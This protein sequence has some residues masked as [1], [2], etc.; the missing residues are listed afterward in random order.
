LATDNAKDPILSKINASPEMIG[1][2]TAGIAMG[3]NFDRLVDT[4]MSET[5]NY[6]ASWISGN[7]F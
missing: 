7:V 6:I 1:L 3:V 5:G 4:V 2:Y